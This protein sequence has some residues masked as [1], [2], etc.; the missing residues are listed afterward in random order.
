MEKCTFSKCIFMILYSSFVSMFTFSKLKSTDAPSKLPQVVMLLTCIR[1]LEGAQFKS[2]M[3]YHIFW[4]NV[5][6]VFLSSSR[7]VLG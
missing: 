5:F 6:M 1:Y 4:L 7:Q 2:Q 3:G